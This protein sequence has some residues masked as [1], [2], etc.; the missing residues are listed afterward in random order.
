MA[1]CKSE[2]ASPPQREPPP[3]TA[4]HRRHHSKAQPVP[5]TAAATSRSGLS[6]AGSGARQLVWGTAS[7][8]ALR[9]LWDSWTLKFRECCANKSSSLSWLP[10]PSRTSSLMQS[11]GVQ[12]PGAEPGRSPTPVRH[13]LPPRGPQGTAGAPLTIKTPKSGKKKR[14]FLTC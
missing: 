13:R 3:S 9:F 12:V 14:L 7:S 6:A 11:Q 4:I 10:S 5:A 2:G 8:P 1:E